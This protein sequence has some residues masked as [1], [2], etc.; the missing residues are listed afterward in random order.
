MNMKICKEGYLV[1]LIWLIKFKIMHRLIR[2]NNIIFSDYNVPKFSRFIYKFSQWSLWFI[3]L[4]SYKRGNW[5][6]GRWSTWTETMYLGGR[7]S[8]A[9]AL[10]W[11]SIIL[12]ITPSFM[13]HFYFL[14]ERIVWKICQI[15]CWD[16]E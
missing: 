8:P 10:T 5:V 6:A 2:K 16:G 15:M 14:S 4:E 1:Y 12:L 13:A 9:T 11:P 3:L 7:V